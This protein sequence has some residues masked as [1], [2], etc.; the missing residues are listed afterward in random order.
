MKALIPVLE[1]L[2]IYSAISLDDDYVLERKSDSQRNIRIDDLLD[3][4]SENF[5]QE[6][7]RRIEDIG[8][9]T[10]GDLFDDDSVSQEI[11]EQVGAALNESNPPLAALAFLESGFEGTPIRLKKIPSVVAA[12]EEETE[13]SIWFLDKEIGGQ[14]ALKE[15]IPIIVDHYLERKACLVVVFTSDDFFDELNDSWEKRFNYLCENVKIEPEIAKELAYSFFVISKKKVFSKLQIG[16]SD[17]QEY[18]RE[19][20]ID[21][22]SGYCMY[23]IMKE[24]ERHTQKALSGLL[25]IAKN[26]K[27]DTLENIHYNMVTEG[28]PNIYH[29]LRDIQLLMQEKEYILGFEGCNRYILAMKRLAPVSTKDAE[30]IGAKTIKDILERFEWAQYQFIHKDT[31]CG[32]SDISCGDVFKISFN[33][34]ESTSYI[35][36][37]VTQPCDCVLRRNKE[38]IS[39][40]AQTFTLILFEEEIIHSS[41]FANKGWKQKTKK[42]RNQGIIIQQEKCPDGSRQA[43]YI[44]ADSSKMALE[45]PTFV[46]D[47]TSL[48]AE[49][50]AKLLSNE[51]L[52]KGVAS[53]KT[54]NWMEYLPS[55]EEEIKAF[56]EL[57]DEL[58]KR[59]PDKAEVYLERIYKIPFSIENQEFAIKRI[60]HLEA[61]LAELIS[62]H[63][64]THTYRA[65]KD[66]L[67]SLHYDGN[68]LGDT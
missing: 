43:V 52:R 11:K 22:F 6:M 46:L 10:I 3:A 51:H 62:Y 25:E 17:A 55:L 53:K 23:R 8:A 35:G 45:L 18:V 4:R 13:G 63:Y 65:G 64:V 5:S 12:R 29:S 20:L 58:S 16:E 57:V 26:A 19:I 33:T 59:M 60:G 39:R 42:I 24:M 37:L 61:N 41:E 49:G 48:D 2:G 47:L 40:K 27:R 50:K 67:L 1:S 9:I 34:G 68:E 54:Q 32:F 66:S 7:R 38:E 56:K 36:V 31:N 30:K 14:D 21:S 44:S 28:E 15:A